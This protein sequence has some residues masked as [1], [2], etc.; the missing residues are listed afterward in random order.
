MAMAE[1]YLLANFHLGPSSRL[2]TIYQRHRQ[3]DRPTDRQTDRTG[4][5]GQTGQRSDC[6]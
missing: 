3:T 4:Q 5:T 6:I 2:A 1:A